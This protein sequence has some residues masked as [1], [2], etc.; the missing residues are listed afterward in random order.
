[1]LAREGEWSGPAGAATT[2]P[3][4]VIPYPAGPD[5]AAYLIYTS[6][7]TGRPKGVVVTP[8]RHPQPGAVVGGRATASAAGDRLL[9]KTTI[10]FDASM[11]EFLR[12]WSSG[13]TVV[14]A[15]PTAHRDPAVMAAPW[16]ATGSPCCSWC[17]R[18]CGCWSRNRRLADCTALRLVCSA[19]RAAA[20]RAVRGAAAPQRPGRAVNTYG[21]TE[22]SDRLDRLPL[23]GV[24]PAEA[25]ARSPDRPPAARRA[26]VR[27]GREAGLVAVGVPGEL[28]VGGVG[29]ARGYLGRAGADRRAVRPRPVRAGR[30]RGCTAPATWCA[31]APTARWSSSAASTT[32]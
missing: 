18:C 8:R 3:P 7:S 30:A 26:G 32:R 1:M 17:P 2:A 27:A 24:E 5:D 11:W 16:S 6:G 12:R 21:P 19:R 13:G 14:T 22:C 10:G 31:G 23:P 4:G 9:Q 15:P 20:R 29:L 28:Y 25:P